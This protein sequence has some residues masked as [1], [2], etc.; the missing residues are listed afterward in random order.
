MRYVGRF[1]LFRQ[2]QRVQLFQGLSDTNSFLLS[3]GRTSRPMGLAA[4][5]E[6]GSV[7]LPLCHFPLLAPRRSSAAQ[8]SSS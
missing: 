2:V 8:V 3:G 6:S 7:A 5:R 4:P 1:E